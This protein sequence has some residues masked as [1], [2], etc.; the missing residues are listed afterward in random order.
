MRYRLQ[1]KAYI[2]M[3]YLWYGSTIFFV[4]SWIK[5]NKEDIY[6]RLI[7]E[8]NHYM[9]ICGVNIDLDFI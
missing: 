8:E 3:M 9:F 5:K 6:L 2:I 7:T 4:V 1:A